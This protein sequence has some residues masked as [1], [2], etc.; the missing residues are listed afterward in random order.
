LDG[1]TLECFSLVW[2]LL[3]YCYVSGIMIW[4]HPNLLF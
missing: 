3:F 1:L 4:H 2:K